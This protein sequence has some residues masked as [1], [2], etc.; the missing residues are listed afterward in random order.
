M[1]LHELKPQKGSRK[2]EKRIGR[3]IGSGH[4][5]TSTKGHKGG[6]ARSGGGGKGPGFEGGQMPLIRR[7]PKRGFKNR[8]RDEASV[9]NLESLNRFNG[10]SIVTPEQLKEAGLVRRSATAVKV[11][12][13][14]ELTKPLSIQAHQF[15]RSALEKIQKAGGKAET[16]RK[17]SGKPDLSVKAR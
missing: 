16:I 14:G 13:Q 11:L 17:A 2:K 3:G 5:K 6:L 1:R 10:K 8:F 7:I 12:G 15:S 4:G 9:V